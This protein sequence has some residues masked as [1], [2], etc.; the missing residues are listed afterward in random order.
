MFL[1]KRLGEPGVAVAQDARAVATSRSALGAVRYLQSFRCPGRSCPSRARPHRRARRALVGAVAVL[2]VLAL[3]AGA[4]GLV[5]LLERDS[6]ARGT[7]IGGVAVGG[8]SEAEARAALRAAAARPSRAA[9]PAAGP[10][11]RHDTRA[12]VSG[13][14][15][16]R[17]RA[18]GG[19]GGRDREPRARAARS[20]RRA[21]RPAHLRVGARAGGASRKQTRPRA[22]ATRRATRRRRRGDA[23][24]VVEARAGTGVDR[25]ALR[26]S[27]RMLPPAV[28]LSVVPLASGRL[29]GGGGSGCATGRAAPRRPTPRAV[30][31][32]RV[33]AHPD[34]SACL[35]GNRARENGSL[36]VTLEPKGLGASLRVRLGVLRAAAA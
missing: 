32:R 25:A 36:I 19:S 34:T 33:D 18:R 9:D 12:R 17:R 10:R 23:V 1:V 28:K 11:R 30:P 2:V 8:L 7:T 29:D 20:P 15:A 35:G 27:L 21:G 24:R 16:T 22:S 3:L 31:R 26:R 5:A 13:P 4:F 6:L 14:P